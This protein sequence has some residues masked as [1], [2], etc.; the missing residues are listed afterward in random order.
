MIGVLPHHTVYLALR[1]TGQ[2]HDRLAAR[3]PATA[4]YPA[5]RLDLAQ[6]HKWRHGW[7]LAG[8][9]DI[10]DKLRLTQT[11]NGSEQARADAK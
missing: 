9:T 8:L 1:K 2:H 11:S 4:P 10:T 6:T 3:R 5:P 7:C